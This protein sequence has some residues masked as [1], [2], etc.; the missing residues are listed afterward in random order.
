M[1]ILI[2]DDNRDDRKVLRYTVE[3][4]CHEVIEAEDGLDG[5]R[6]A[7]I[8]APDL[9]I[10]DALMPLMDGF[11]FLRT[12][13]QDENLNTIPF[14]FYSA[15]YKGNEDVQLALSLGADAYIIKPK[16]PVELWDE[17]AQIITECK[18]E[19]VITAEVITEES[20]Y[21]KRYSQVVAAKLEE[22]VQEL[23]RTLEDR[24]RAE[25]ALKSSEERYRT[26]FECMPDAI[27][28]ADIETG[29]ICDANLGASRLI[30]RSRE[31][32]IGMH[33][34][35]LHPA[36]IGEKT[37]ALF[38]E[39]SDSALMGKIFGPIEHI[40]A[41]ADGTEVPIEIVTQP[42]MMNG[43]LM[44][45][46]VFRDISERKKLEEQLRHAQKLEALGT[47]AGGVAHDFN[48]I[49]TIIVGY[50]SM[51]EMRL[52]QDDPSMPYVREILAASE[53]ATH[54][55]QS[56]LIFSRKQ[57]AELKAV[58]IND[59][60]NGMKKMVFRII[61]EDIK[62]GITLAPEQLMV[63]GDYGQLEQ[64][65]MNFATNARDAMPDGGSL[66]IETQLFEMD[67]EFIHYHGFGKPGRYALIVVSDTGQGID[68]K[69]RERI[70]EPFFTTKGVAKGT[71]LGLAIVYGI[72]QQ[73]NGYIYCYSEQGKG[74][75]FRVYLPL[76]G[77]QSP[78]IEEKE[79]APVQGGTETILVADDDENVRRL[80][81]EILSQ[82][83]Y[84]VLEAKD[85][86]D[87]VTTFI[88]NRDKI[89]LLLL[90]A[91][92]P[93][94]SGREAYEAIR[95]IQ[96]EVKALFVCGYSEDNL[97]RRRIM[98][99]NLQLLQK[100]VKPRELLSTIREMLDRRQK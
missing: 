100:P 79:S 18:K 25:E 7:K 69:T 1:K 9:I 91:I 65:L 82:H 51:M 55:I 84:T 5:L 48:N 10:S 12:I 3:K 99:E 31:D 86:E 80:T 63:M 21:L 66:S 57:I 58:N 71:G 49:L 13:K 6:K 34:S 93:G 38:K 29:R 54:L 43:T 33:Q 70:F 17:V 92:M 59:V 78:V 2:V 50:G 87:A 62:T 88:H 74:T 37:K 45:Q 46:G 72:V 98:E 4:N 11:Q 36:A 20:E 89:H 90:D 22:K 75:T 67:A 60:V 68:E 83:G 28:I 15:T 97:Q 85:G 39:H 56:L 52:P 30:G 24:K 53:R 81:R 64:V 40:A 19:K 94:K 41:R 73:H 26:L 95:A 16:D 44:L 47:L 96:P 35:E 8:N 77:I 76:V 23:E 32:L 42:V 27:F 14:I 61:G